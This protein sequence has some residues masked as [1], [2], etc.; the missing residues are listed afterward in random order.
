MHSTRFLLFLIA[1]VAVGLGTGCSTSKAYTKRGL[2]MEEVGM[3]SQA[4]SFYYTA[5]QKKATIR[6]RSPASNAQGNGC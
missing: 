6:T 5:V 1:L 4:A 2:K 3:M